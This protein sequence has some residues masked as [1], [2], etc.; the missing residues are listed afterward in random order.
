MRY[1]R[2]ILFSIELGS[3]MR[4]F[5]VATMFDTITQFE[6]VLNELTLP[7]VDFSIEE[8]EI[9]SLYAKDWL[10]LPSCWQFEISYDSIENLS[11]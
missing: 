4:N 11:D 6:G 10:P 3:T 5:D 9:G 1:G 7:K 8:I 2:G